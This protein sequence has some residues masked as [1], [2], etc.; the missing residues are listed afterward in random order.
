MVGP[1]DVLSRKMAPNDADAAT[2]RDYLVELLKVA[3]LD[4]DIGKRPFGNSGWEK[5]IY[6]ELVT[7]GWVRGEFNEYETL[8]WFDKAEADFLVEQAIEY[9]AQVPIE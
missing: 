1:A 5:E 3:W 4:G 9:L 8:V 2:I 7:A 6:R